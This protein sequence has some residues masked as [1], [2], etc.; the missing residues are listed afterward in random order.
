MFIQPVLNSRI[1]HLLPAFFKQRATIT[2][3]RLP[4][5]YLYFQR[6]LK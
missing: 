2:D 4:P 3:L 6:C 5:T 1:S